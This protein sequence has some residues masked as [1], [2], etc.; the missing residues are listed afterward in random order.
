MALPWVP[1]GC[2]QFVIVVFPDHTHLLFLS[3]NLIISHKKFK[4]IAILKR[5]IISHYDGPLSYQQCI[6]WCKKIIEFLY[7]LC[8]GFNQEIISNVHEWM[9]TMC[10]VKGQ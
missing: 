8:T 3:I 7:N 4:K 10:L 6:F 1:W 2:L 9:N 5:F